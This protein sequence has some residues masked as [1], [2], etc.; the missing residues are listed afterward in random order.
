[1]TNADVAQVFNEIAVLL[2][3]KGEDAFRVNSYRRVARTVND[4]T[5]DINDVAARGELGDLPGV[6]PGS[7]EKIHE[8]LGTGRVSL[9]EQLLAEVPDSLLRLLAVPTIGPKRAAV[10]WKECGITSMDELKAALAAGRLAT[11]KGFGPKTLIQMERGIEFLERSAGRTRLGMG[12]KVS[13]LLGGAVLAMKGV[14]RAEFAGSLRRGCETV[15]DL[16]LLCATED[17]EQVVRQF[18]KLQHVTEV[19]SATTTKGLVIVDYEPIGTLRV[20]LRVVPAASFGAAWLWNTGSREH[21]ARLRA[22]AAERGWSLGETGLT[23]GGRVI[24]SQTEEEIYAALDLPWIPPELREDRGEFDVR[25]VPRDLLTLKHIRGDLHVHTTASD[26]RN[27]VA[28]MVEAAMGRGYEYMCVTEHSQS[29]AIAGGLKEALLIGHM[30]DVR[31]LA[32]R[33][34]GIRVWIG[35][36]VDILADG[37]LDYPD[38]LLAQLDFVIASVH[39]GMGSD[40]AANT[41]RTLAAI[42]N[43]Y[44]NCIAHPTGRLINEREAMALDLEAICQEAARTGTALEINANNFRLDLRDE[45][46]RLARAHHVPIVIS[47]DAHAVDQFDQIQFGVLTARRAW[48]RR[49]DVLNTRAAKDIRAFVAA[50]RATKG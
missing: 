48:L 26:G 44:V 20:D 25:A 30:L 18:L 14:E 4:L 22:R 7:A 43:P 15:G 29:S 16:D 39:S 33:T 17:P 42:R 9:R 27:T 38:E 10:L 36:E 3:I 23:A 11:V 45:H 12:W 35:T 34:E 46:A 8:L 32:K 6:G 5:V 13:T 31:A 1:M 2:E 24:A 28:E 50:K 40:S 49:G 37:A 47:T 19:L 21:V 41:R